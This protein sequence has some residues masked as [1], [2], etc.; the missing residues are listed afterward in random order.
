[1]APMI[2]F[3]LMASLVLGFS[4][5]SQA[6]YN[7]VYNYN[8]PY[9]YVMLTPQPG[10]FL[11]QMMRNI[12][13]KPDWGNRRWI[14]IIHLANPQQV[15][16]AGEILFH[17]QDLKVPLQALQ[18]LRGYN[19]LKNY[20][21]P[22]DPPLQ[23]A[24]PAP[25]PQMTQQEQPPQQMEEPPEAPMNNE[26]QTSLGFR[27][28]LLVGAGAETLDANDGVANE[29]SLNTNA[30]IIVQLGLTMQPSEIH[31]F[32]IGVTGNVKSYSAPDSVGY[33]EDSTFLL[34]IDYAYGVRI[35][36]NVFLNFIG[37]SKQYNYVGFVGNAIVLQTEFGHSFG[38]GMDIPLFYDGAYQVS[39]D[40][41]VQ[42][43][44]ANSLDA[45]TDTGM[46][47][48]TSIQYEP[49]YVGSGWVFGAR[50]NHFNQ[51]PTTYQD[52]SSFEGLGFIGYAF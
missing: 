45:D 7:H 21:Q 18:S 40:W 30:D 31:R 35:F 16:Q 27:F 43:L 39:W 3:V 13:L 6:K 49:Q 26:A 50:L 24:A 52:H 51:K 2:R 4:F 34:D 37:K 15:D 5:S 42:A 20:L 17:T 48:S 8:T 14:E 38:L 19:K 29:T 32:S 10:V 11:G 47:A 23:A 28:D 9:P 36:N 1:M 12:G 22:Y 46:I 44:Y 33:E 25:E 41:N